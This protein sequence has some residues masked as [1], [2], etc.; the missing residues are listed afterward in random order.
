MD[1]R[2]EGILEMRGSIIDP[3]VWNM[4][5]KKWGVMNPKRENRWDNTGRRVGERT[6][7]R[8]EIKKMGR[9]R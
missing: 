8:R 1:V 9:I 7:V 5:D 6:R 3:G 4:E 2:T